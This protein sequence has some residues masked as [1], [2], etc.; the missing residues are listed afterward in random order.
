MQKYWLLKRAH[1]QVILLHNL[2]VVVTK[3]QIPVEQIETT[4]FCTCTDPWP[5]HLAMEALRGSSVVSHEYSS[6]IL[7][8]VT[9]NCRGEEVATSLVTHK[10]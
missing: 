5:S 9:S 4:Q 8:C 6:F 10:F 7:Y 3:R 2:T 1:R